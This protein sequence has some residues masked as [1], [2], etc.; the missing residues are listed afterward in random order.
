MNDDYLLKS[1]ELKSVHSDYNFAEQMQHDSIN[2]LW[3][4]KVGLWTLLSAACNDAAQEC[5]EHIQNYTNKLIDIET[6]DIHSLKSIAKSV[7]LEFL[8]KNIKENYPNDILKLINLLSV[9]RHILLNS[10]VL[11]HSDSNIKIFGDITKRGST[12]NVD[13]VPL[14]LLVDIKKN[15]KSFEFR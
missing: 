6:C 1:A 4:N 8:T 3:R 5:Y 14:E 9:P 12:I 11:L 7:D 15:I 10:N 13:T 2:Q